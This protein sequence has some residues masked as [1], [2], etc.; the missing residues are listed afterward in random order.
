MERVL[1]LEDCYVLGETKK[2]VLDSVRNI[3]GVLGGKRRAGIVLLDQNIDF[4]DGTRILGTNIAKIL[5][6][7]SFKGLVVI[8]TANS[9]RTENAVYMKVPGVDCVCGKHMTT[10]QKKNIII[11]AWHVKQKANGRYARKSWVPGI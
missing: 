7:N 3:L 10:T 9:S 6:N 1:G 2:E 4:P 5:H 8:L 11:K